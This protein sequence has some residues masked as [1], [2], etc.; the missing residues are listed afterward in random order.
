VQR[1]HA[2]LVFPLS[3]IL[4]LLVVVEA[5]EILIRV[6]VAV[7]EDCASA[8]DYLLLLDQLIQSQSV[9]VVL[10]VQDMVAMEVFLFLVFLQ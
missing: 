5:A 10:L 1:G 2:Q 6:V 3:I 9:L 4:S 8:Q 7:L